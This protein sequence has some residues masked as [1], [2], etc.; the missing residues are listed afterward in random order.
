MSRRT[1]IGSMQISCHCKRDFVLRGGGD[2]WTPPSPGHREVAV[3]AQNC[4]VP[5]WSASV[6]ADR[7]W[8]VCPH[9]IHQ[10][11]AVGGKVGRGG[12]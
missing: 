9:L 1:H 2:A 10:D 11:K 5:P 4:Q 6:V 12:S 8:G 7:G 3:C